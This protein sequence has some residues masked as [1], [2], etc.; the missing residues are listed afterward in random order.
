MLDAQG[1]CCQMALEPYRIQQWSLMSSGCR[2][3][4]DGC[5]NNP[6]S[7]DIRLALDPAVL[8]MFIVH[9]GQNGAGCLRDLNVSGEEL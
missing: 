7:D 2:W 8:K 3:K 4:Y 5:S 1:L 6:L 9:C